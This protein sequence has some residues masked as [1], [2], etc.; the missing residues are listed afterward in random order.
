MVAREV[1]QDVHRP[2]SHVADTDRSAWRLREDESA[3]ILQLRAQSC[4]GGIIH[5][6]EQLQS[7]MLALAWD[8][9]RYLA[10]L[11]TLIHRYIRALDDGHIRAMAS[12]RSNHHV[13]R[14]RGCSRNPRLNC[15]RAERQC[16]ENKNN[17]EGEVAISHRI[18]VSEFVFL[19]GPSFESRIH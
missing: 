1:L 6:H 7:R 3:K 11:T 12:F 19:F 8:P 17:C 13:H 4:A 15:V 2:V 10:S 5:Q 9:V 16:S 14:N 18:S